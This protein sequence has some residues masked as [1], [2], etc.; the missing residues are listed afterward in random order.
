MY[1][2]CLSILLA[3]QVAAPPDA[4]DRVLAGAVQDSSGG[5][6]PDARVTL[7]CAGQEQHT[8]SAGLDGTFAFDPAPATG[9][10]VV[11]ES[12]LFEP[13]ALRVDLTTSS[14]SGL[15]LVLR[16]QGFASELVVTPGRGVEEE[17]FDLPESIS[18]TT[19]E[20]LE[21]RPHQ[22]LPQV[23][24]EEPGI[25]LQQTTTAHASPFI[26]GFS[27]QRILY[28]LDGVRFNTSTFRTGATQ[29][30]GW[31]SPQTV[32][33][34]EVVRG[35]ASVQYGSDA[36][37]GTVNV[38]SLKPPLSP[39]GT[40][41][42]GTVSGLAGSAD[43]S[44]AIDGTVLIQAPR[45]AVQI[46][47]AAR[48][49]DELRPGRG[50][51]SH[52]A[53]TRFLGLPSDVVDTRLRNTGFTQSGIHILGRAR[54]GRGF[55]SGLFLHEQQFGVHRYDR[56]L[57]GDGRF[58]AEF[59]PQRLD[60]GLLQYERESAGPLDSL[61]L[62][63]SFNR[64]QDDR[65]DQRRAN[66]RIE[67]DASRVLA[68]GYQAQ[69]T[70]RLAEGHHVTFGGEVY[71]EF[72]ATSR[73]F[74]DPVSGAVEDIRP[75]IPDG[76]RYVSVGLFAQDSLD[77]VPGRLTLRGGLR[78]GRFTFRTR[79]APE[80]GVDEERV[81]ADAVTF[82]SGAVVR[83]T[84]SLNATLTASR[85]F[86]AANALDLGAIGI[87]G[88]GFE[89]SPPQAAEL[90]ARIGSNGGVDAVGTGVAVGEL[91]PE[92]VLAFEAGLKL[93]TARLNAGITVFNLGLRDIIQRRTAIIDAPI[94]GRVIAGYEIERQ[95]DEGRAFVAADSRPIVTRV[96]IDR[97]RVR[98]LE[99]SL[100]AQVSAAWRAGGYVSIANGRELTTGMPLRR[101]PP[102]LGG[103]HLR[104]EPPSRRYWLEGTA[105][106]AW[107][108]ARLSPGDL[109]DARI[110][111]SRSRDSIAD[112]FGG[113]ATDLGLV[114]NALLVATGETLA[115]VQG[116][117]L[118][119]T[120][121]APLQTSSP[122][123]LVLGAR[124]GF[125]LADQADVTLLAENLTDRNYRWHGSGVD[126]AGVNL[127]LRLRYRF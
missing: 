104:V 22:L 12:P 15:I 46:G 2:A 76:S 3:L 120:D 74:E 84:H 7:S 29:Y 91:G 87:S 116:R 94:V 55:V 34:I 117:V 8:R 21:S 57:G 102:P 47:G 121:A 92:T 107:R 48:R 42:R 20:E 14:R 106:F 17:T 6:V 119:T 19:R 62:G 112:F 100:T 44:G 111:A 28:L 27:A 60:V 81:T 51:D 69:A 63:V 96:N 109:A 5:A 78:Y 65:I 110:G 23:L 113:T 115:E 70:R 24:K 95:D 93:Q 13:T 98:G 66:E 71:D 26:R 59:T 31:I 108:Q 122:G 72:I 64:Q 52:A 85:G 83:L 58:R 68:L 90:G 127:Q 32:A 86:R 11:A 35:P 73:Q 39:A 43:R 25:L 45:L 41:V 18:V 114:Q 4:N 37:G 16:V 77:L 82:H 40:S 79:G 67:R 118:G 61:R 56:E 10:T 126:G 125:S 1:T 101:M 36:L 123:F 53:V 50:R 89:I 99:A 88:G 103:A 80:F 30:L 38:I 49:V 75:R 33:R 54:A 9:C 97:A 105:Q 124:A